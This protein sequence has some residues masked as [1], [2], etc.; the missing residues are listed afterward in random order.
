ML[1][2]RPVQKIIRTFHAIFLAMLL[3]NA[4]RAGS[5][6]SPAGVRTFKNLPGYPI[7]DLRNGIGKKMFK[8]LEI[9]PVAAWVVARASIYHGQSSNAKIVHSEADGIFDKM[10]VEMANGYS[11][12]GLDATESRMQGDSLTVHLLIYKIS[13]G[14]MAV[15]VSHCDDA[16]YVG[17]QQTGA[18]WVGLIK[19]GKITTISGERKK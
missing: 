11:L 9:S 13:D 16:R 12:S 14:L 10:L 19:D 15:R 3:A 17:Y 2:I 8:S 4:T 5:P 1:D 18:A 6:P 7:D